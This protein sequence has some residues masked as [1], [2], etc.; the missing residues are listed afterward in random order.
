MP[1][2]LPTYLP[3]GI[4]MWDV[5][6]SP[7]PC[8]TRNR[9][10]TDGRK[11]AWISRWGGAFLELMGEVSSE[12]PDAHGMMAANTMVVGPR[13]MRISDRDAEARSFDG[14]G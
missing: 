3:A 8:K 12:Q 4:R 5:P 14:H 7:S 2:D 1:R 11:L 13:R 10:P 6:V 9:I